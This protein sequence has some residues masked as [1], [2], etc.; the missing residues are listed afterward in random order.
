M[1]IHH[2]YTSI[3]IERKKREKG[4][5]RNNIEQKIFTLSVHVI[6]NSCVQ[7]QC[8]RHKLQN[9]VILH[10]LSFIS[11]KHQSIFSSAPILIFY[12]NVTI[13]DTSKQICTKLNHAQP[14]Y[15]QFIS[16]STMSSR[17]I[18]IFA[19]TRQYFFEDIIMYVFICPIF[20]TNFS[21]GWKLSPYLGYHKY[22]NEYRNV[23]LFKILISFL[24]HICLRVKFLNHIVVLFFFVL[25]FKDPLL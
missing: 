19:T 8:C 4:R 24:L 13:S 23:Y 1:Y 15:D 9:I 10:N 7:T 12:V 14:C 17:F 21:V 6:Y 11:I 5:K 18:H 22:C 20:L 25:I 2:T 16:L 3:H